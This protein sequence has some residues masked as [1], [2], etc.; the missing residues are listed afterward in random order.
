MSVVGSAAMF[1]YSSLKDDDD[2]SGLSTSGFYSDKRLITYTSGS[3]S[4]DSYD[5]K[6]F[7]ESPCSSDVLGNPFHQ[8]SSELD[9]PAPANVAYDEDKLRL[10][11]QE[12]EKVLLDDNGCSVDDGMEID[13]EWFD[14]PKESC[15]SDSNL[16]TISMSKEMMVFSPR[17]QEHLL[18]EC[19]AAIH[20]GNLKEAS[21]MIDVLRQHV[22]IQGEPSER[23]AAYMVEALVAR[24]AS[25]GKGLYRAL[26]CKEAP[27]SDRL[28]A[29]QVLFEVCPCF[30]FGFMAANGAMLEAFKD[31][32]R[33]HIVDFD[34][35]QGSQYY[36]LLQT[37][38]K[39][40]GKRLH[41]RLTG[42]DD[43]ESVQRP[44]GGL[45]I[46]GQRLEQHARDLQ[47]SFEFQALP[48][49]TALVSPSLLDCRSGEALVVNF[50][51][52]LHHLPDESVSTVNLR[53]RLLR[54]I[55]GLKPKLVTVVE[56]DV[57]TNTSPFLQRFAEA[58]SYYSAVF[59]SLEAALGRNSQDRMNVEK[60][61][62]ARDI[63]NVVACEGE[64]RIERYEVAGKWRA[65]MTMAGFTACPM[66]RNVQNEI[67]KL[68]EQYSDRYKVKE[69][70]GALHFG[71]E[72]KTL[73]V[74][75][76]WR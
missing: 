38:A 21:S 48:A 26:R 2:S 74:S 35:N 29:M 32:K 43:P 67:K 71:W 40:P 16:S 13:G 66:S 56:Q 27:S 23:I 59:E 7:L 65:R 69:E 10:K 41:L 39:T 51:F 25:S 46:I 9:S 44:V 14:S 49:E 72:E 63:I 20:K 54:M 62:L 31:E 68:I 22:S 18:F 73:I 61:C 34:V 37:L 60:H 4:S 57:N 17:S 12:L 8:H 30:R 11:L 76:A 36:T 3:Y 24:M 53:D 42:V 70:K 6:Y 5:P 19:A 47:L 64:E 50:A 15:S 28:S 1:R 58:Y 45:K 33:V 75:S 55:K 52:L